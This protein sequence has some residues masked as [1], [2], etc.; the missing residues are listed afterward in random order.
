M[1]GLSSFFVQGWNA[2]IE[3]LPASPIQ[4]YIK[5]VGDIPYLEILNWFIP[6]G[7]ILAV[8]ATWLSV[9][10]IFYLY[11]AIIKGMHLL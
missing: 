1:T 2:V 5:E 10:T 9:V 8:L 11:K 7:K 6:V 3:K 4:R